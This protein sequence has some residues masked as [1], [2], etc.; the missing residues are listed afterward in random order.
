MFFIKKFFKKNE[1]PDEMKI[2][3]PTNVKRENHACFDPVSK[4]II[5]LPKEWME[6]L[7]S[8][9]NP[10][11]QSANP[12]AALHAI[13][14]FQ[15]ALA[16]EDKKDQIRDSPDVSLR[17]KFKSVKNDKDVYTEFHNICN[18]SDPHARFLSKKEI[19]KGASGVVLTSFDEKL[20]M[21]VAIKTIE[22]EIQPS[23]KAIL[24]ELIVLRELRHKNLVNFLDAYFIESTKILWLVLE[25][26]DGGSLTDVVTFISLTE[27]Q[28]AAITLEVLNGLSFLH[29]KDIIHRDIKSDNI[30]L[31][32]NGIVKITDFGFSANIEGNEKRKTMVR[33]FHNSNEF[34]LS[35][36]IFRWELLTGWLQK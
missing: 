34:K 30:L 18:T 28:I 31:S 14:F 3:K 11:E 33:F 13:T 1:I 35:Q 22:M 8:Q 24:N 36:I 7:N 5:G 21:E 25:Y 16:E 20:K 10:D 26:M 4:Q 15:Q 6:I 23:K 2:T 17:S 12:N 27:R 19:G 9:I 29:E 32:E